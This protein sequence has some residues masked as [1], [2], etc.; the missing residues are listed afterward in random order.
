MLESLLKRETF[1]LIL[2]TL[3]DYAELSPM[4]GDPEEWP[5]DF[6]W[7]MSMSAQGKFD[8]FLIS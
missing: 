7:A 3:S 4:V 1:R 8:M 5:L 2:T 6:S